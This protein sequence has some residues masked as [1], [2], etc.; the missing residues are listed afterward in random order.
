MQAYLGRPETEIANSGGGGCGE[1][2]VGSTIWGLIER[3]AGASA[4]GAD[5]AGV[6][7]D[8]AS[9]GGAS[10]GGAAAGVVGAA[11]GNSAVQQLKPSSKKTLGTTTFVN[12]QHLGLSFAY[13]KGAL[14]CIHVYNDSVDGYAKYPWVL[15]AELDMADTNRD[16]VRRLGEPA[17]KGGGAAVQQ[18][19]WICYPGLGVQVHFETMDWDVWDAPISSIAMFAAEEAPA[20]EMQ[21]LASELLD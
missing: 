21:A 9:A 6:G 1:E 16:V 14:E 2:D 12:W 15:G 18:R 11:A 4:G 8:G 20:P 3:V 5:D 17:E 19:I 13:E 10:A 7:A